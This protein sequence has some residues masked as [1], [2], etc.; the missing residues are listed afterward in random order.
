METITLKTKKTISPPKGTKLNTS[1]KP[2]VPL[3]IIQGG[4]R[5]L[6]Y[7]SDTLFDDDLKGW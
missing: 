2:E 3:K 4:G 5:H 1:S 7:I 6:G